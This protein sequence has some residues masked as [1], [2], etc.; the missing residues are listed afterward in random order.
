MFIS[1]G[2]GTFRFSVSFNEAIPAAIKSSMIDEE[3]INYVS[4]EIIQV[5]RIVEF[6]IKI[7]RGKSWNI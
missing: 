3:N 1:V 2:M 7:D 6:F 4:Y 5:I